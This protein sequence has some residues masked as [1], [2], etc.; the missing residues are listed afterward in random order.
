[1]WKRE[2]AYANEQ[3]RDRWNKVA[4]RLVSVVVI[5]LGC[6]LWAGAQNRPDIVWARGGSVGDFLSLSIWRAPDGE[7]YL[8]A[9]NNDDTVKIWRLSDGL[10]VRTL[11]GHT[12]DVWAVAFSP[13]GSV[14]ASGSADR[15]VRLWDL[16][17]GTSR[18]LTG[19]TDTVRAM[20]FSPNGRTLATASWDRTVRLWNLATGASTTLT[21]HT[22]ALTGVAFSPNGN[23]LASC[24]GSEIRIWTATGT[25][26][27]SINSPSAVDTVA[28]SPNG[29]LLAGACADG[30]VRIWDF[31]T[32]ELR[33]TLYGHLSNA[34][35][36]RF[37]RDGRYLFSSSL[38]RTVKMWDLNA[39]PPQVVRAFVGHTDWIN[40][41]VLSHNDEYLIS[42]S[43][44]NTIRQW[45]VSDGAQVRV[46]TAHT[47]WVWSVAF[48]P[49]GQY[50]ASG[51]HDFTIKLW[52]VSDGAL[53]AVYQ[54]PDR[55]DG[56]AFSPDGRYL[57]AGCR[58]GNVY[59]LHLATGNLVPLS[60][61][62]SAYIFTIASHGQYFASASGEAILWD[63]DTLS[64]VGTF[65]VPNNHLWSVAISP[66][67]NLLA[68]GPYFPYDSAIRLFQLPSGTLQAT[69]SGHS[70]TVMSLDFSPNGQ[71]LASASWDNTI[72]LWDLQSQQGVR[73]LTGQT[74]LYSVDFSQDG[75]YLMSGSSGDRTVRFWRVADGEQ[76]L[77]YDDEMGLGVLCVRFSPDGRYFAY[78][79]RDGTVVLARNPFI[80]GD[81]N[82]DGCIDDADLLA[83]LFAFGQ[84]GSGLAEDVNGDG[85]VDDADLLT[86]LFAFGTGC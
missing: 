58:D 48:S 29:A 32:R 26:V 49:D 31:S 64:A 18:T 70:S 22:T 25:F 47:N 79:R 44:D 77:I 62:T 65:A 82:E 50:L 30:A 23:Y 52:R 37:S 73:T 42:G 67:G 66:D 5:S 39:N 11:T 83:V 14:L 7:Q 51:S 57:V 85:V 56:I 68:I 10:L 41:I 21:G 2:V 28:F 36:V 80:P 20:A 43:Y 78:S 40:P 38:D 59:V 53:Q 84:T 34:V 13:D 24:A 12:N 76:A 55:I 19:H 35:S 45:R 16:A 75:R 71:T 33:H 3:C 6:G 61:H 8:A 17:R 60:G 4:L 81:V 46:L 69:L 63:W 86:V 1:M 72:R 54:Y 15:T 27:A 74:A 9:G